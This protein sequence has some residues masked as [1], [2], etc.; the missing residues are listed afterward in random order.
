MADGEVDRIAHFLVPQ[1]PTTPL[2][3]ANAGI[4]FFALGPRFRG[5]EWLSKI[6]Q[7]AAVFGASG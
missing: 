3:P 4:Q 1:V 2:I 5:N 7:R 6:S